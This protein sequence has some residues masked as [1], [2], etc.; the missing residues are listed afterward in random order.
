MREGCAGRN[1]ENAV[2]SGGQGFPKGFGKGVVPIIIVDVA[3]KRI[4]CSKGEPHAP[5][6]VMPYEGRLF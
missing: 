5:S 2:P 1:I 3:W 4:F 6:Y